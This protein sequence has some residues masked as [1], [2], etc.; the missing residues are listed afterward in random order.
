[1]LLVDQVLLVEMMVME[2]LMEDPHMVMYTEHHYLLRL[3][4]YR[5]AGS[6]LILPRN[7]MA[8]EDQRHQ[9]G[10]MSWNCG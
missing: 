1:M 2:V 9:S 10:W 8:E 7:L 4:V 6:R 3:L 5:H